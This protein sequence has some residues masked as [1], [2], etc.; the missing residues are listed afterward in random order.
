M[1]KRGVRVLAVAYRA[2]PKE[3]RTL[4][5][6][7]ANHALPKDLV[8][9]GLFGLKD[10]LRPGTKETI[11]VARDAGIRTIM[12]T[13]D[14]AKTAVA[15]G[16]E[17]GLTPTV[18]PPYQG[19]ERGGFVL[20]GA[21]LDELDDEAL[22][23]RVGTVNIFA[24]VLPKH[25]VRIVEAFHARGQTVAM[26]GDGVND[27]PALKAADIGV[28][29]GSGTDVA[30]ESADVVLTDNN[31]STIVGAVEGGRNIYENIKKVVAYLLSDSW[32]EII[33]VAGSLLLGLPL[34]L[35]AAQIL[36]V[37][38]IED[39]LPNMALA[40]DPG[41]PHVMREKP[42]PRSE[43]LLDA[44]IKVLIFGVGITTSL[45]LFALYWFFLTHGYDLTYTRTV[46]FVGLGINSL[47][48]IYSIRSLHRFIWQINP[49][50]NKYLL[51]STL[52]SAFLLVAAIYLAPLRHILRTV[53]LHGA[54]W[55]PLV[56]LG[57]INIVLIELVKAIFI[58][59]NR[60]HA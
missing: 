47:F 37:N 52:L 48:Y 25:K 44:E 34:P 60:N 56:G 23:D 21:E 15:I 13:G 42:R 20:T 57:V 32:T 3:V 4:K 14:H 29:V 59:K 8:F 45:L 11:M 31:L 16:A 10:P 55:L 58:T 30:K 54:A 41:E 24:R 9:A 19:G 1:A 36:W 49:F 27:A 40:F 26:T 7:T 39:S 5:E 18:S 46:V 43:K 2:V 17:L 38:L 50:N 28:A 33:V 6:L 51:A 22:K 53:P 12:I 35:L